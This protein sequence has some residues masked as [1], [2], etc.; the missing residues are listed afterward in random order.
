MIPVKDE[1]WTFSSNF[2]LVYIYLLLFRKWQLE[3][4]IV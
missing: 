4:G 2:V 3:V 1:M